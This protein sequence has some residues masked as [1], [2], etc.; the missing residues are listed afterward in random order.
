[1]RN[2]IGKGVVR[3]LLGSP[4]RQ[5]NESNCPVTG[6]TFKSSIKLYGA[7][8]IRPLYVDDPDQVWGVDGIYELYSD[9]GPLNVLKPYGRWRINITLQTFFRKVPAGDGR[10][11]LTAKLVRFKTDINGNQSGNPDLIQKSGNKGVVLDGIPKDAAPTWTWDLTAA[12]FTFTDFVEVDEQD[13]Y[14]FVAFDVIFSETDPVY[15][16][17][18]LAGIQPYNPAGLHASDSDPLAIYD[19]SHPPYQGPPPSLPGDWDL[20]LVPFLTGGVVSALVDGN[21][22][23]TI[24]DLDAKFPN[25]NWGAPRTTWKATITAQRLSL[26]ALFFWKSTVGTTVNFFDDTLTQGQPLTYA[27]D[28]GDGT[29]NAAQNPTYTYAK[30]G[31]YLVKLTVS[32]QF[33]QV[34]SFDQTV[35]I[36]LQANFTFTK[37]FFN[38]SGVRVCQVVFKDASI[39]KP[40]I[41]TWDFGDGVSGSSFGANP[42]HNY[43]PAGATVSVKM[44]IDDGFGNTSSITKVIDTS[45]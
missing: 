1:M 31:I 8:T 36:P 14:C 23:H 15:A 12:P 21:G 27:W 28:F 11:I 4:A 2:V 25:P 35:I 34:S 29:K 43:I 38:V 45:G 39:G 13:A 17:G 30:P 7:V 16:S 3:S 33:G 44:T 6:A 32:D 24:A 40:V 9:Q 10:D 26:F 37:A 42:F 20:P 5:L 18:T 22:A 19:T 41:W